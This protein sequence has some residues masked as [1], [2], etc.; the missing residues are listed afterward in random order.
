MEVVCDTSFLMV[1]CYK[2]VKNMDITE[3]R[4]GKI[5]FLIHSDIISELSRIGH[6]SD[7]IKRSKI[8]NLSLEVIKSQTEKGNFKYITSEINSKGGTHSKI[9]VSKDVDSFL[10]SVAFEKKCPL[11][12]I[13]KNLIKRALRK[14][15]DIVTLRGNKIIFI[16][17]K[18]DV[19]SNLNY[20]D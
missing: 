19:R 8:A 5:I 4:I 10:L 16:A 1:V 6:N 2:P 20:S 18:I 15:V 3:S 9:K 17:S 14:G 11:A 12:T 7:G 13:D